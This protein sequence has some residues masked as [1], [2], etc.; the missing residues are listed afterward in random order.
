MVIGVSGRGRSILLITCM[1]TDW[2]GQHDVMLPINQTYDKI[3]TNNP[4]IERWT[5]LKRRYEC[6][7]T[8]H[9]TQQI[10]PPQRAQNDV[11][12]SIT[13]MTWATV[14]LMLKSGIW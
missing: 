2:I 6:S 4:S 10:A 8:Q 9:F 1:I 7:K 14:Q 5:I 3:G 11:Y 12:C 13:S